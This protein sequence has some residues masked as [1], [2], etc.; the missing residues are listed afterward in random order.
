MVYTEFNAF[1]PIESGGS[2]LRADGLAQDDPLKTTKVEE[3]YVSYLLMR[4]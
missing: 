3:I 2:S 4:P 1:V